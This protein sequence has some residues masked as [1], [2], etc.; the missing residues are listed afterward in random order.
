VIY[1]REITEEDL[2]KINKYRNK[3]ELIDLLGAPFRHISLA[4]DQNWFK[5]Y[6]LNKEKNVRC[7]ICLKETDEMV[8][9][10]YLTNIDWQARIGDYAIAIYEE[11]Y[12]SKGIGKL[13]TIE[14]LNHG[15]AD[16]NLNR[17]QLKVIESNEGAIRLYNKIGFK[18]EGLLRDTVFKGGKYHNQVLM[19]ILKDDYAI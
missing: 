3:K 7:A 14:I 13:A 11:E 16:L 12:R 6:Q 9:V 8:G 1:I 18:K 10:V 4:M 17:I 19:S 2:E 15:F 5:T